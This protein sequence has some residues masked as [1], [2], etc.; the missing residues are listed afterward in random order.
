MS[1][2][3]VHKAVIIDVGD[4]TVTVSADAVGGC[5]GCKVSALCRNDGSHIVQEIKV[6]DT[7]QYH[8][9]DHVTLIATDASRWRAM[10]LGLGIPCM[11]LVFG[12]LG[13]LAAG[14][15]STLAIV[16]T[17]AAIILYYI[18]LAFNRNAIESRLR[19]TITQAPQQPSQS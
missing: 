7:S 8:V 17:F 3:A 5:D 2:E 1:S 12:L 18:I 6:G 15:G 13:L 16:I 19:W 10:I 14:V 4:G 9:G 11:L